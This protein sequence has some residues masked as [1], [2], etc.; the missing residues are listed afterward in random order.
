LKTNLGVILSARRRAA[1]GERS[2]NCNRYCPRGASAKETLM[3]ADLPARGCAFRLSHH[4]PGR[5]GSRPAR[6][7][8]LVSVSVSSLRNYLRTPQLAAAE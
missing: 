2:A 5:L 1:R 4:H 3:Q 7:A 6:L 8:S